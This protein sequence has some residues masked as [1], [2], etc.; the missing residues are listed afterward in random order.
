MVKRRPTAVQLTADE[1]NNFLAHSDDENDSD[2]DDVG[3]TDMETYLASVAPSEKP[4][5]PNRGTLIIDKNTE[6]TIHEPNNN[7]ICTPVCPSSMPNRPTAVRRDVGVDDLFRSQPSNTTC[8]TEVS[9]V[10]LFGSASSDSDDNVGALEDGEDDDVIPLSGH[11][12]QIQKSLTK[13]KRRQRECEIERQ[14]E[15]DILNSQTALTTAASS[16]TSRREVHLSVSSALAAC[17][18]R[19]K[20]AIADLNHTQHLNNLTASPGRPGPS[21]SAHL[22]GVDNVTASNTDTQINDAWVAVPTNLRI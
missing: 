4:T 22:N 21:L 13:L 12:I 15:S 8:P 2:W 18:A 14:I 10:E 11:G 5:K 9:V 17:A 3:E 19:R 1:I 7:N 6:E 16:N 20:Q